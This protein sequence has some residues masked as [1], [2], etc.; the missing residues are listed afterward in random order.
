MGVPESRMTTKAVEEAPPA[1]E[2][3]I[4]CVAKP[5]SFTEE[6]S[7]DA[8]E[9]EAMLQATLEAEQLFSSQGAPAATDA[10]ADHD[11]VA[12]EEV[13]DAAEEIVDGGKEEPTEGKGASDAE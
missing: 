9:E 3:V 1:K 11:S 13:D 5:P 7:F 8:D 2:K 10:E 12:K 6:E 4:P